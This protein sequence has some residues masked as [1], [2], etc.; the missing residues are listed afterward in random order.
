METTLISL[1]VKAAKEIGVIAPY[2]AQCQKIRKLLKTVENGSDVTVGS[3][4]QFQGQASSIFD[5][6]ISLSYTHKLYVRRNVA[7]S[8]SRL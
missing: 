7:S 5:H 2:H 3:V 1:V 6:V 8:S 4:E